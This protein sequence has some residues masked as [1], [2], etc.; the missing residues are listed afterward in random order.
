MIRL[1]TVELLARHHGIHQSATMEEF[2]KRLRPR[3]PSSRLRQGEPVLVSPCTLIPPGRQP[4]K[5]T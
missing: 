2:A 4:L 1:R 5:Q 3:L